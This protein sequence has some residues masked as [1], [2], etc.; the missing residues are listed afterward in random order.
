MNERTR[1]TARG[2]RRSAWAGVTFSLLGAWLGLSA[3]H[4]EAQ[5]VTAA[6]RAEV[7][8]SLAETVREH[9][10]LPDASGWLADSIAAWQPPGGGPLER[11]GFIDALRG[12]LVRWS[13]DQH[14]VLFHPSLPPAPL[15][16]RVI[17]VMSGRAC[18]AEPSQI[19]DAWVL[20]DV[21]RLPSVDRVDCAMRPLRDASK[22]V[23]DLRSCTGGSRESVARV[24]GYFLED[25]RLFATY[26]ERGEA[27]V[28]AHSD[29]VDRG[30][31]GEAA[32]AVVI[33]PE[34][35]SGCEAVAYH[36][37]KL[38][39]AIIVGGRSLGAA[40]A[41]RTFELARGYRAF[42][43]VVQSVSTVTGEDWEG[44]GVQPDIEVAA[45]DAVDRAIRALDA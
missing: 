33:G 13:G 8:A 29:A 22:V 42:V 1:T 17:E 44:I 19:G 26:Y 30:T 4:A 37:Q 25:R 16:P 34:T 7:I 10:V 12:D 36:L 5:V 9:Y 18:W 45:K 39:R 2:R 27:P 35:A 40:H 41:V 43:P 20:G 23:L 15:E 38:A 6:E 31:L 28:E 11:T 21:V 3:S 32:V 14:F 24:I